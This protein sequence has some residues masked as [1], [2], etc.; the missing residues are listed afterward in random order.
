VLPRFEQQQFFRF[1]TELIKVKS[2][3]VWEKGGG[4]LNNFL[5][6]TEKR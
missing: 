5:I 1:L 6:I 2:E 4:A 3:G